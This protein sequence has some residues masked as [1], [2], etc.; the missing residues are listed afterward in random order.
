[1]PSPATLTSTVALTPGSSSSW[2]S[3]DQT[4]NISYSLLGRSREAKADFDGNQ[5]AF[6]LG[7]GYDFIRGEGILDVYGR[8]Q[9]IRADIDSYRERGA[10]GLDLDIGSQ[11]DTSFQSILG[12]NYTRS[13]S[14]ARAVLV[15][16]GWLEWAHEFNDGDDEVTGVFANDP[17]RISFALATDQ[18]DSDYFRIGLGLGAQF[19]QGR[20]AFVSYEAAIGLTDYTEHSASAGVRLEF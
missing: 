3:Y 13:I 2:G 18:F 19:G 5:Y 7:A 14:T 20:T 1:M 12:V 10:S 17:S 16:Q 8:L 15:P 9:Y 6:M 4:R 11:T